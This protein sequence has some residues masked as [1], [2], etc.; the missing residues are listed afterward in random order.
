MWGGLP[1]CGQLPI[2]LRT[3]RRMLEYLEEHK[4]H[5]PIGNRALLDNQVG[6]PPHIK[7]GWPG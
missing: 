5:W 2:G 7:D 6:N 4:W 3:E 1:T